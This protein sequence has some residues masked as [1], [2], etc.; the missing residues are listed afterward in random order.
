[1]SVARGICDA[2]QCHRRGE[3]TDYCAL[4]RS[5][6]CTLYEDQI[7]GEQSGVFVQCLFQGRGNSCD[8]SVPIIRTRLVAPVR[9]W[10]EQNG[11]VP[12]KSFPHTAFRLQL[13]GLLMSHPSQFSADE[14]LRIPE[15]PCSV[16]WNPCQRTIAR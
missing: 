16:V 8:W 5:D 12:M 15:L 4:K 14:M 7:T 13:A 11:L 6:N 3:F 1:V 2:A 9:M 10:C